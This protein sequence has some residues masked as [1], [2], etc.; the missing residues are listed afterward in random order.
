MFLYNATATTLKIDNKAWS[1]FAQVD[2]NVS[3]SWRLTL[4][5]RYTWEKRDLEQIFYEPDLT[6]ISFSGTTPTVLA[7]GLYFF[8]AGANDFNL[9][10]SFIE[11]MRSADS[12][13]ATAWTPMVSLQYFL[14]NIG[15]IDN[16]SVY[17]TLSQGFRSGGLTESSSGPVE[18]EPEEVDN[19]ELGIKIDAFD[20]RLRLNTALFHMDYTDRQLTTV[21]FDPINSMPAQA[22]IN[23]KDSSISGIEIEGM[24]IPIDGLEI[25]LN[26]TWN[27]GRIKEFEDTQVA[28]I[29]G[30]GVNQ[31]TRGG[32][33]C[34]TYRILNITPVTECTIDRSDENLP[35]LAKRSFLAAVQYSWQ[36][37]IGIVTPRIQGSWKFDQDNCFDRSSCVSGQWYTDKQFDLSARLTWMS[38]DEQWMAA[39][40]GQNLTSEVYSI[41]GTALVDALGYGGQAYNIP[42]MYG[43][44]IQYRW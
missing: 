32:T 36:T 29:Q 39:L 30:S 27:R 33:D 4:G 44:E 7:G 15:P 5:T 12:V 9:N 21:K 28:L 10:H 35:R 25:T 1:A 13:K 31:R 24:L 26:A 6:T 34:T 16:G 18:F 23:A 22:T 19:V 40:Y 43:A 37:P 11:D 41:G 42:K 14:P 17:L 2:W 20:N 38:V 8:P 3:E